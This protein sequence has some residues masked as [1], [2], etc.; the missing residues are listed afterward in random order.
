LGF[1]PLGNTVDDQNFVLPTGRRIICL[2]ATFHRVG[3]LQINLLCN[4]ARIIQHP[5]ECGRIPSGNMVR[6]D[7]M[8]CY[9]LRIAHELSNHVSFA[10]HPAVYKSSKI[11]ITDPPFEENND[12]WKIR[13]RFLRVLRRGRF[14]TCRKTTSCSGD[15]PNCYPDSPMCSCNPQTW[16]DCQWV[17]GDI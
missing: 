4:T 10:I 11:S 3:Q 7:D 8:T 12:I 17:C 14:P 6:W 5:R 9:R 13:N 15:P 2:P 16:T 1:H